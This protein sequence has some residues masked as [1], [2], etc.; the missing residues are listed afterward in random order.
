MTDI[1]RGVY[2]RMGQARA[3]A[4]VTVAELYAAQEKH[5]NEK[6]DGERYLQMEGG[7]TKVGVNT[8]LPFG[9]SLYASSARALIRV[10]DLLNV[11][12][13]YLL[14]REEPAAKMPESGTGWRTGNPEAYG[15]YAAYVRIAEGCS[16]FLRELLWDGEEWFLRGE[17][18][19]GEGAVLCWMERPVF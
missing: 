5:Y 18:I 14:G 1:V 9:Y 3:A 8:P 11:S 13:D 4:G 16:P 17:R 2:E 19:S 6:V 15:T 12:I 10:A 7:Q